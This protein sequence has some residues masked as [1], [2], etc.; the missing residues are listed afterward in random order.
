MDLAASR[1]S[2]KGLRVKRS[3]LKHWLKHLLNGFGWA[4][5]PG[6]AEGCPE[7]LTVDILEPLASKRLGSKIKRVQHRHLSGW[8][9]SGAFKLVV[10]GRFRRSF[11]C[12]YKN[13]LYSEGH[14]P[15]L[16]GLPIFP[17][18]PEYLVYRHAGLELQQY[19]PEIYFSREVVP[20]EHFQFLIEDL[21]ASFTGAQDIERR[22]LFVC[23]DL[24]RIHENLARA[25]DVKARV[26][27]LSY[28]NTFSCQ[29]L[30]YVGDDLQRLHA[31]NA[32]EKLGR[33]I[34]SWP[35]F[36][37]VYRAAMSW[38]YTEIPLKPIHGDLNIT[39]ILFHRTAPT[40]FKLIDWEW[41]GVGI[42]HSDLV[43]LLKG[44]PPA[45]EQEALRL[46]TESC[47]A[48][49]FLQDRYIYDWCKLQRGLFDAGFFAKQILNSKTPPR[50]AL[51]G[52]IDRALARAQ[53]AYAGLQ[54]MASQ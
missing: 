4:M 38:V 36:A 42:P 40:A 43:S 44:V 5:E 34:E 24:P 13:A 18:P 28:D 27:L 12:V 53:D 45:V 15:A 1:P 30:D 16:E 25:L 46:Y 10:T 21:G 37:D 23:K 29:L 47:G 33:L 2:R 51:E 22:T 11:S 14:I 48:R 9:N 8:K 17:G 6:F 3:D 54:Q 31:R 49:T 20:G 32:S 26:G 50:M 19:L 41:A 35:R 7:G 52:P 39:N